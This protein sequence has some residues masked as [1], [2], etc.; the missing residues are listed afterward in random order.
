[1]T[2]QS[3]IARHRAVSRSVG[4][5]AWRA[6]RSQIGVAAAREFKQRGYRGTT[7]GHIAQA[8]GTDRASL[9]YYVSGKQELFEDL[10]SEATEINLARA[11]E[12]RD[13]PGTGA[14]R[15]GRIVSM[16]MESIDEFYPVL[17]I[18]LQE[19]LRQHDHRRGS[20]AGAMLA[21][22]D[23]TQEVVVE[24]V[25]SGQRDGSIRAGA[26]A[27]L[28]GR[29]AFGMVAWSHRWYHPG[30]NLSSAGEIAELFASIALDGL[31]EGS[32]RR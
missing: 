25:R 29:G 16:L 17:S 7:L 4:G 32:D 21:T 8:L 14:E 10:V 3:N 18:V 22:V 9:Y 11:T 1:L 26:P 2:N 24:V 30:A 20:W 28:I 15:L 12:I 6:R 27:E 13:G 23:R 31:R 19:D 5:A